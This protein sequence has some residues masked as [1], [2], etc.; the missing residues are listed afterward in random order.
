MGRA[1]SRGRQGC[2]GGGQCDATGELCHARDDA[3]GTPAHRKKPWVERTPSLTHRLSR[4]YRLPTSITPPSMHRQGVRKDAAHGQ[5][6]SGTRKVYGVGATAV[7]CWTC[8]PGGFPVVLAAWPNLTRPGFAFLTG[9]I[10]CSGTAGRPRLE[11]PSYLHTVALRAPAQFRRCL[12]PTEQPWSLSKV[13]PESLV[14][15]PLNAG[16]AA[17]G[18]AGQPAD[19]RVLPRPGGCAP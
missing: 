1:R 12:G 8:T 15:V 14:A 18:P 11:A 9:P 2:V 17:F 4:S 7:G 6:S 13:P 3:A 16:A 10:S 5:P 19:H